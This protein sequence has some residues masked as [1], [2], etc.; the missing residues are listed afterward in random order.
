MEVTPY[1]INMAVG[2]MTGVAS[3]WTAIK[4]A[5]AVNQNEIRHLW[6]EIER[7]DREHDSIWKTIRGMTGG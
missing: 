6:R 5:S 2:V 7:H 3:A 1:V 4:V